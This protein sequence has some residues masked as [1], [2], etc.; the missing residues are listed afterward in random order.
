MT[1][2]FGLGTGSSIQ[3]GPFSFYMGDDFDTEVGFFKLFLFK[4]NA[5]LRRILQVES[6]FQQTRGY[7]SLP[8]PQ[9]EDIP[10]RGWGSITLTD[11][12]RKSEP[13]A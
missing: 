10:H 6:I 5:D 3:P 7:R 12:Q 4:E 2:G 9:L 8:L 11:I 13:L 1:I